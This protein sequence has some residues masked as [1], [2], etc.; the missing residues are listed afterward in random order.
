[1]VM[2]TE[3]APISTSARGRLRE[4]MQSSQLRWW[5]GD[6]GEMDVLGPERLLDDRGRVA[7]EVVAVDA[8]RA[9]GAGEGA[10]ARAAVDH[11]HAVGI[12]VD[13]AVIGAL[14]SSGG[15]ISTGPDSSMPRH[16][17]AMS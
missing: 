17:C 11:D 2:A 6:F 1:M 5:P 12:A 13:H 4:R 16:H 3:R 8:E 9:L 10:A 7:A 15:M 14:G